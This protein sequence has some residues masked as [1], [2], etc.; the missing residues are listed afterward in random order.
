MIEEF[1]KTVDEEPPTFLLPHYRYHKKMKS[2]CVPNNG[3]SDQIE[4]DNN[5]GSKVADFNDEYFNET[6][7]RVSGLDKF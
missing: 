3:N 5:F 7:D 1:L 2:N 6:L 4:I